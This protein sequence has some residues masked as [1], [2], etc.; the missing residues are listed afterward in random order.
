MIDAPE[1]WLNI[2]RGI[3]KTHAPDIEVKAFG[4]RVDGNPKQHSDLDIVLMS[5]QEVASQQMA[6][7][8][9]AFEESDLP[10]KIDV[11]DWMTISDLF[12][13]IIEEKCEV[14]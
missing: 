1:E 12:K 2:V 6:I 7:L 4:S 8:K 9:E 14:L 11:V 10:I 13:K 5:D 3:L